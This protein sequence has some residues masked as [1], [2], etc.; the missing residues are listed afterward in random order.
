MFLPLRLKL[1][2]L[3]A[4]AGL[5]AAPLPHA[6]TA[7]AD[8]REAAARAPAEHA[9]NDLGDWFLRH[10]E[11]ACAV[12]AFR[13]GIERN[14]SSPAIRYNLA[15]A[16]L[17]LDD[18]VKVLRRAVELEPGSATAHLNLGIAL[19]DL[20]WQ[21]AALEE[22]DAAVRLDPAL[23]EAHSC[24]GRALFEL[25]RFEPARE[26]IERAV[27][28]G[29]RHAPAWLFL[30]MAES[31]LGR[32]EQAVAMLE[33]A[34]RLEPSNAIAHCR[35]GK[36]LLEL[37]PDDAA[38]DHLKRAVE[39]D[40]RNTQA[41]YALMRAL[42]GRKQDVAEY[43]RRLRSLQ[44]SE[45]AAARARVLSNFALEAARAADWPKAVYQLREAIRLCGQCPI[46]A[47]LHKNLGLILAQS[48]ADRAAAAELAA[49]RELAPEDCDIQYALE[50]LERRARHTD[51]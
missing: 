46:R 29:V 30:G 50:L 32:N 8:L 23:G 16:W 19:A 49:A 22:F 31:E 39:L 12:E 17:R 44:K 48:G 43:G 25:G 1:A 7:P 9:Y 2:G 36:A 41:L 38:I 21:A 37:G 18:A 10:N 45:Q 3:V 27:S 14:P 11:P 13:E 35:L 5:H 51:P 26:A 47:R 15:L 34:L 6:C 28:L 40:A 24:R 42:T 20:S 33:R 4:V